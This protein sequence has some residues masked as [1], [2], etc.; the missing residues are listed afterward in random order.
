VKIENYETD[1]IVSNKKS[2]LIIRPLPKLQDIQPFEND[3]Y[4]R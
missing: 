3:D 4:L 1:T 2:K